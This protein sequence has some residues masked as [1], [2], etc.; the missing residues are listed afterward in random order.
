M[1]TTRLV[2]STKL[3]AHTTQS[4]RSR[5][6]PSASSLPS[7]VK[8]NMPSSIP[9]GAS[10]ED[11]RRLCSAVVSNDGEAISEP[12]LEQDALDPPL[13]GVSSSRA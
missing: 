12:Q 11:Q 8:I 9:P 10:L 5:I 7:R 13:L 4:S 6:T 1:P 2:P 3:R